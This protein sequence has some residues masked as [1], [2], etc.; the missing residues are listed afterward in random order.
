[1][2]PIPETRPSLILRMQDGGDEAAWEE[3]VAIYRPVI[4]RMAIL[5]GLQ[6]NDAEDLAQ[7][8][9]ISVSKKIGEWES[10]LHFH[11]PTH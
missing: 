3:F 4:F 6:H 11:K 7:Q 10:V 5:K 1:M 2:V 9:L 8:V